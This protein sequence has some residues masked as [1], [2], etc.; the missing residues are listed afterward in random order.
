MELLV[1]LVSL[2]GF[3]ALGIPIA[4]VLVLCSMVHRGITA[5]WTPAFGYD[6]PP[7]QLTAPSSIL[8]FASL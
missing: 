6:H 7:V 1:F 8:F 5:A 2:F 4:I 3:L